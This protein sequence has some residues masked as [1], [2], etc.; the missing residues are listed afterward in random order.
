MIEA[1]APSEQNLHD[2]YRDHR[3]WLETWLRRRMGNAWDAADLSQDTFLR[4]FCSTQPLAEVHEPRAYL[5]T[6]GKRLLSNFYSRRS[7]EAAYLEAL[8]NQ[9]Q[10]EQ[11]SAE[12]QAQ[13][14]EEQRRLNAELR[15]T[16]V[17][18]AEHPMLAEGLNDGVD[19]LLAEVARDYQHCLMAASSQGK[20]ALY[21]TR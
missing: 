15:A 2:L 10:A 13:A 20:V 1:A 17:L 8:A 5:L 19:R 12:Q 11:P 4:V 6:V 21:D 3:G 7:L 14:R 18:L 16:R 9:P